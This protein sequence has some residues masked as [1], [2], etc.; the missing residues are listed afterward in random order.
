[1]VLP[2]EV[3]P[4]M[5]GLVLELAAWRGRDGY[6]IVGSANQGGWMW[7]HGG[8]SCKTFTVVIQLLVF[9]GC[10]LELTATSKLQAKQWSSF[11]CFILYHVI[12]HLINALHYT[13]NSYTSS[14][15][16]V[17]LSL[18]TPWKH[19]GREDVLLHSFLTLTPDGG[20]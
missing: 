1:M 14:L 11:K 2:I 18:P 10:G 20:E 15:I 6:R 4:K 5:A 7:W 17:R 3:G 13:L 16:K 8:W 12:R 9:N 19:M